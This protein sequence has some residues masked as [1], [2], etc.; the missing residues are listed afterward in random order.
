MD[1]CC[2]SAL[3]LEGED[4]VP[5]SI[6]LTLRCYAAAVT[7][8]VCGQLASDLRGRILVKVSSISCEPR[9]TYNRLQI[10]ELITLEHTL[11]VDLLSPSCN[12]H[13]ASLGVVETDQQRA[14]HCECNGLG[15]KWGVNLNCL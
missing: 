12:R 13:L 8:A 15:S 7:R 4:D 3:I 9:H 5:L 1:R 2:K 10:V 11:S 14:C 6:A